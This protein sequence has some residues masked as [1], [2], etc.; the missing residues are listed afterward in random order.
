[1]GSLRRRG[2]LVALFPLMLLA[3]C[4]GGS[5][6]SPSSTGRVTGTL[7]RI[8]IPGM[9]AGETVRSPYQ[10]YVVELYQGNVLCH[11]TRTDAAGQFSISI[12]TGRYLIK[13][14]D[15]ILERTAASLSSQEITVNSGQ[16][17]PVA[18]EVTIPGV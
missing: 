5:S 14:S 6:S 9:P 12:P 1:M 13:P 8:I 17:V 3:G 15:D 4:G 11:Q 18:L 2:F 7:T 10:D 16:S